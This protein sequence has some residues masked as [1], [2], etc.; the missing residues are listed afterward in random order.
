MVSGVMAA[1][2]LASFHLNFN[3]CFPLQNCNAPLMAAVL[4]GH[5]Q[6]G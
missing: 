4:E 6:H 2:F 5:L 3:G 1:I